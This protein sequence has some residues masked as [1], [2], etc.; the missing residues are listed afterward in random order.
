MVLCRGSSSECLI[1]RL[2]LRMLLFVFFD[3][4]SSKCPSREPSSVSLVRSLL[5]TNFFMGSCSLSS[6]ESPG[7]RTFFSGAGSEPSSDELL[8]GIL[9]VVFFR[10]SRVE[11]LLQGGRFG[12]SSSQYLVRGLLQMNFFGGS[13]LL[14]DC[15]R[16]SSSVNLLLWVFFGGSSLDGVHLTESRN[17]FFFKYTR[18]KL[19]GFLSE[20]IVSSS[21]IRITGYNEQLK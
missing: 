19:T 12:R 8:R 4:S 16:V 7:S 14:V 10:E 15:Y 3:V 17:L 21:A 5:Q 1:R 13:F 18:W 9:F 20:S 2:I 11:N 6:S